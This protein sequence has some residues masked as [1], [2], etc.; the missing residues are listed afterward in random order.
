MPVPA[1]ATFSPAQ[2]RHHR[3]QWHLQC[4]G[5]FFIRKLLHVGQQHDFAEFDGNFCQPIEDILI[6]DFLRNRR[7]GNQA[8]LL[9]GILQGLEPG[10]LHPP[11]AEM[12][13][14]ME[15]DFEE[16]GPA[17]GSGFKAMKRLPR[18]QVGLL[19]Q[20]FGLGRILREEPGG[21]IKVGKV[22]HRRGF[23][24]LQSRLGVKEQISLQK[25]Q[26]VSGK[27]G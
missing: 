27:N 20:V 21:S 14:A 26:A 3:P 11:A 17:I 24:I 4:L 7:L 12:V 13:Q 16:P 2:P 5:D 25:S 1:A 22:W 10:R 18:L 19:D 15:K 23:K 8:F 9:H 6:A